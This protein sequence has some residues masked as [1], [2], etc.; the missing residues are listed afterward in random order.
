MD[1]QSIAYLIVYAVVIGFGI[2]LLVILR[3]VV[4]WWLGTSEIIRLLEEQNKILSERTR[5]VSKPIISRTDVQ[6]GQPH[7]QS[8]A[9]VLP[10]A[11]RQAE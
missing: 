6:S 1:S 8:S 7:S 4:Q 11:R 3:G 10:P 5:N 2:L 9:S